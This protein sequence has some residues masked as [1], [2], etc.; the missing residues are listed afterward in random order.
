MARN[1]R[2]ARQKAGLSQEALADLAGIDRTYVSGIER[3][4]R[5]PTITIVAKFAEALGTTTAALL[6]DT[7]GRPEG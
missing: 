6:T 3:R 2:L 1:L 7:R 5:N 4:V